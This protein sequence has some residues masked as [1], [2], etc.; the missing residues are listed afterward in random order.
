MRTL[1][2][3]LKNAFNFP[4]QD[5][6]KSAQWDILGFLSHDPKLNI[7]RHECGLTGSNDCFIVVVVVVFYPLVI[8]K[9]KSL[10][11]PCYGTFCAFPWHISLFVPSCGTF[12]AVLWYI[13]SRI[14]SQELQ[15]KNCQSRIANQELPVKN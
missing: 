10:F 2:G 11:V 7:F 12:C 13:L 15:I 1:A 4:S 9:F 3:S 8:F 6:S 14:A 5:F